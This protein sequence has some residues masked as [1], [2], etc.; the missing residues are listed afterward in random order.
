[1]AYTWFNNSEEG[2]KIRGGKRRT[3]EGSEGWPIKEGKQLRIHLGLFHK[4]TGS[5]KIY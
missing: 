5:Q 2:Y 3:L 1:M 4:Q